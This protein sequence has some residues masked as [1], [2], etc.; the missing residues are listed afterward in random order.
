[1]RTALGQEGRDYGCNESKTALTSAGS[2]EA[3]RQVT[4]GSLAT[5]APAAVRS[6]ALDFVTLIVLI[7]S[8]LQLVQLEPGG[9]Y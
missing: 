4:F 8:P 2:L 9:W 5:A 3:T 7:F 6:A 1:M